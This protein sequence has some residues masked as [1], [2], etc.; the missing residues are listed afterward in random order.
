MLQASAYHFR[1][2]AD[3]F[4]GYS[5]HDLGSRHKSCKQT[6]YR[7]L[8]PAQSISIRSHKPAS[9]T[10]RHALQAC[11]I[12]CNDLL[13]DQSPSLCKAQEDAYLVRRSCVAER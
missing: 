6:T 9:S 8:Q 10:W 11:N 2:V 5:R 1:I 12:V 13:P 7:C 3:V 4:Q